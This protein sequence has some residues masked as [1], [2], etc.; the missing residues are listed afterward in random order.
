MKRVLWLVC[1]LA[2]SAIAAGPL[3]AQ[4]NPFV[5]TW[6]LNLAKSKFEGVPTPKSLNRTVV[7]DAAGATYTFSGTDADGNPIEYS[8]SSKYD[9]KDSAVTGSGMPGGA[10]TVAMT[11][12]NSNM[13]RTILKKGGTAIGVSNTEVSRDGKVTT[14][15]GSGVDAEGKK[16]SMVSVYDEQ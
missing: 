8:F 9:G 3:P 16:F 6:K 5:G 11:R 12:V 1:L 4:S 15:K 14:V 10:D 2:L 13:V 7:A